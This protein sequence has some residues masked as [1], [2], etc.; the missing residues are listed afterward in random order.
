MTL[1]SSVGQTFFIGIFGPSVRAEFDLNHTLWSAI[2]MAGTLLSAALLPWTGQWIDRLPL[3]R[4]SLFVAVALVSAAV[5]MTIVPAAPFLVLAIFLLRQAGQG[6][7][8][9][10]GTTAV[11]RHFSADRGKAIAL[12]SLGFAVGEAVLPLVAVLTIAAIGWRATYGTMAL[13]V[14]FIL[15]ALV[16]W[17]LRHQERPQEQQQNQGAEREPS[18]VPPRSWSRREVLR[19]DRFYLLLPAVLAPSCIV[20]ALFFHHLELAA[21]KGWEAAWITGSY[22]VYALGTVTASLLTGPLID[23]VTAARVLPALLLPLIAGLL[24]VSAF[25]SPFW[26]WPYLLLVG[27]TSGITYTALTAFWAEAYGLKH[28]GS[29]RSMVVALSV[30]ASAFGPL[31][32][33][34][35]MDAGFSIQEICI[36]F[37][38]YSLGASVILWTGLR[39]Y[40]ARLLV[41]ATR[42]N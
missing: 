33:G 22:W 29:I 3:R 32:M 14:A 6:L 38:L 4:F 5:I 25:D 31:I 24:I 41:R 28:L 18:V 26:A 40:R 13:L 27:V 11:A 42:P 20:T 1:A 35:M 39:G 16:I 37:A 12:A 19:H 30:L 34:A 9:H 10:T 8:S 15:P 21:T 7:A 36:G 23:R 17:L 2:Y